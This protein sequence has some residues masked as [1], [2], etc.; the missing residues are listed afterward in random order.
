MPKK[1]YNTCW[2]K[3]LANVEEQIVP[4]FIT[5][6]VIHGCYANIFDNL[7]AVVLVYLFYIIQLRDSQCSKFAICIKFEE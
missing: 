4:P 5:S 7:S 6:S 1:L 2:I 3:S